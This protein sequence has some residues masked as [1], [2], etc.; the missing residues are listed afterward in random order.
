M[1]IAEVEG[2]A[3]ILARPGTTKTAVFGFHPHALR[4]AL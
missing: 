1:T 2:S 4:H 3:A